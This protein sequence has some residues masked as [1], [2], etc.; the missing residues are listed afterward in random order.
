MRQGLADDGGW[1]P[2]GALLM[3]LS[4]SQQVFGAPPPPG[5]TSQAITLRGNNMSPAKTMLTLLA[6][7]LVSYP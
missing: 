5:D 1:G 3:R 2:A 4:L 7:K 6:S